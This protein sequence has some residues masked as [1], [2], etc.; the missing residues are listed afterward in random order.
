MGYTTE[1]YGDLEVSPAL[2][3]ITVAEFNEFCSQRHEG[4][5]VE[6]GDPQY[7]IWCDWEVS[8]D[9]TAISWNGS[10][11]S[12]AMDDWLPWLLAR[13]C[14]GHKVNGV[15]EA[16]GEEQGDLWAIV[17]TDSKVEVKA[18]RIVWD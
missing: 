1:F 7:S 11:K 4:G 9:G 6:P 18:A 16:S 2:S 17:V 14:R 3:P 13:F 8:A 15:I 12:Y 5:G 10:E